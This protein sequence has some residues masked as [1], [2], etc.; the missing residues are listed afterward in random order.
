VETQEGELSDDDYS[1]EEEEEDFEKVFQVAFNN[2][3]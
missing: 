3:S 2:C 1:K